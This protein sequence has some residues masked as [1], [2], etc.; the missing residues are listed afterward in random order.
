VPTD[1]PFAR[2]D[3]AGRHY[4]IDAGWRE[5]ALAN[6]PGWWIDPWAVCHVTYTQAEALRLQRERDRA[7]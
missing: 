6:D 1:D 2:P 5:S 7:K 3:A 4:L